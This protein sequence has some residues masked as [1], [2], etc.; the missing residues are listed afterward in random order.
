MEKTKAFENNTK[1]RRILDSSISLIIIIDDFLSSD[2]SDIS[3]SSIEMPRL[4]RYSQ[5]SYLPEN[6]ASKND[7]RTRRLSGLNLCSP[8]LSS[9]EDDKDS[10]K[11]VYLFEDLAPQ[12][13]PKEKEPMRPS[14]LIEDDIIETLEILPLVSSKKKS[15]RRTKRT[16]V[17]HITAAT[18]HPQRGTKAL[19]S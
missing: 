8:P 9:V 11:A 18:S 12:N 19:T 7:S 6:Y 3:G 1:S 10:S 13:Q 15:K 17:I 5:L 16:S 4:I 14:G 2:N